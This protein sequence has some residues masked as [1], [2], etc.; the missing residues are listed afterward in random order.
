MVL[1]VGFLGLLNNPI[2]NLYNM[3]L[4]IEKIKKELLEL[5]G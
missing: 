2:L 5:Y 1:E 3:H 4:E